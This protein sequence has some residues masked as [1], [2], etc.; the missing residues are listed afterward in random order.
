MKRAISSSPRASCLVLL[1]GA[2]FACAS[3]SFQRSTQ[4]L[5]TKSLDELIL[6][7]EGTQSSDTIETES[8]YTL[9]T[10][11][12]NKKW[13]AERAPGP[14]DKICEKAIL[15]TVQRWT[16]HAEVKRLARPSITNST[17]IQF[18][19]EIDGAS[20]FQV[21]VRLDLNN[22]RARLKTSIVAYDHLLDSGTAQ[23]RLESVGYL[24]F[25]EELEN[26]VRRCL[27]R[28]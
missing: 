1:V 15:Q 6:E 10:D 8:V 20:P 13:F 28:V 9:S 18:T 17:V 4:N 2:L 21:V 16:T 5:T 3:P 7:I 11:P 14:L 25:W 12:Y 19:V 23:S 22:N 24:D 27:E 26:K